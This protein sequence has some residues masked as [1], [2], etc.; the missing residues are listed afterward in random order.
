MIIIATSTT[1]IIAVVVLNIQWNL[2]IADTIG[3]QK[4]CPLQRGVRYKEVCTL[5]GLHY[6]TTQGEVNMMLVIVFQL[7]KDQSWLYLTLIIIQIFPFYFFI[8][9]KHRKFLINLIEEQ[10]SAKTRDYLAGISKPLHFKTS[11]N[12]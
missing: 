6:L 4:R 9:T 1:P 12:K 5:Q 3:S 7:L 2:S 10:I 11:I 8:D